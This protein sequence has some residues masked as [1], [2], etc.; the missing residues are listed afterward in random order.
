M[1]NTELEVTHDDP[2]PGSGVVVA[3]SEA[4]TVREGKPIMMTNARRI[5]VLAAEDKETTA[6]NTLRGELFSRIVVP[7]GGAKDKA[8][9]NDALPAIF[10]LGNSLSGT[11]I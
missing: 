5:P 1:V 2:E 7:E 6:V 8:A 4:R 11:H 3:I 9:R 10:V